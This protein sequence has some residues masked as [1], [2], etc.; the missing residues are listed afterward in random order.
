[1][2]SPLRAVR[3]TLTPEHIAYLK[4]RAGRRHLSL[5]AIMRE[6]IDQEQDREAR[7]EKRRQTR[8]QST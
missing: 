8:E 7:N 6:L 4:L 5:S 3:V 2:A 1:M